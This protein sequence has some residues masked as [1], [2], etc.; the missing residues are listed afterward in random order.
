MSTTSSVQ[1]ILESPDDTSPQLQ[2]HALRRIRQSMRSLGWLV[3]RARV[4]L[5]GAGDSLNAGAAQ[6]AQDSPFTSTGSLDRIDKR[7]EVELTTE[8]GEP[9][10]ITSLARDWNSALQ[11]ALSRASKSLL[12]RWQQENGG[13]APRRPG[14]RLAMA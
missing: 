4:R 1:V 7:C 11:S 14:R 13:L 5:S 10:V 9:V 3:L 8:N 12:H 2:E 6:A